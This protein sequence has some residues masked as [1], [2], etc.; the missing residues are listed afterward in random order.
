[1]NLLRL[2][3]V[4]A[5]P[6][7]LSAAMLACGDDD[8]L[9]V[10][11]P[12]GGAGEASTA[13]G[14]SHEG[15]PDDSGAPDTGPK[16]GGADADAAARA[17][18]VIDD[19]TATADT[20]AKVTLTWT[21]PAP[22]ADAGGAIS[23][24]EVKYSTSP[25]TTEA[26]FIAATPAAYVA[27]KVG[28]TQT[29]VMSE[30]TPS[31]TYHFALR[32]TDDLGTFGPVSNDAPVTTKSR[33]RL[34][35]TEIAPA[36]TA[37]EG[38]D[39]I[40][41]VAIEAGSVAELEVRFGTAGGNADV[42]TFGALDVQA[43]DRIVVHLTGL[44]GPAGFAQEDVTKDKTSS[45]AASA[46][47]EAFD[48]YVA[49]A[50][51]PAEASVVLVNDGYDPT[52]NV[53]VR[54]AMAYANRSADDP[55]VLGSL[56]G[57]GPAFGQGEWS[58]TPE[59]LESGEDCALLLELVNSSG[60]AAPP[61]GGYPGYLAPGKSIQRNG[62]VDTNSSADFFVAPQT[63]A[64][65]NRPFCPPESAKLALTEVNPRAGLLELNVVQGG[66]VR[67]FDLRTNPATA[68]GASSGGELISLPDLCAATGDTIVVHLGSAAGPSETSAKNEHPAA[69]HPTHYDGAWDVATSHTL[70]FATT[71]VVGI[72]NPANVFVEAAAFSDRTTAPPAAYEPALAFVQELG[73]WLPANCGG[74]PC[75]IA[76]T[77]SARNVA[78]DWASVGMTAAT[79]VRRSGATAP[80]EASS[81]SVE[82]SSFGQ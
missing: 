25:I 12:D 60:D 3:S 34:L 70:P 23:S 2:G 77:P 7:V 5:L 50:D 55:A 32:A 11:A 15:G 75:S 69:T 78:A 66:N 67:G 74:Q 72:R 14:G 79:S 28:A 13:D 49:S 63:R 16:D 59:A 57:I 27:A 52:G 76:T 48:V 20:H 58:F 80:A 29:L 42:Y 4:F 47:A 81:W 30:L 18:G 51:L 21:T 26:E 22:L 6:L 53:I 38:G 36:N 62:T 40:E 56:A 65:A 61:C 35:I 41:L 73:L 8:S 31:T 10:D 71:V 37:A 19:L 45:T 9:G 17:P 1:M 39:F 64:A 44:P 82:A 68:T 46:S 54:D 24:Y 33:A 43:G